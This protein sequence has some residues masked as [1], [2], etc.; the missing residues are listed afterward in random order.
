MEK[1]DTIKRILKL[2]QPYYWQLILSLL[3]AVISVALTLYAP[4]LT[5]DAIDLILAKE[6]VDFDGIVPIL[7]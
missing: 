3:F 5:G 7:I 2:I 1:K 4:I 6:N